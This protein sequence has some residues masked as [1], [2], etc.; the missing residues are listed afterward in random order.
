MVAEWVRSVFCVFDK[1]PLLSDVEYDYQIIYDPDDLDALFYAEPTASGW[2]A[3]K[4]EGSHR[5]QALYAAK[6]P[7]DIKSGDLPLT[8]GDINTTYGIILGNMY[9]LYYPFGK[10]FSFVNDVI[11]SSF[12]DQLSEVLTD[13]VDNIEDEL[14]D[15]IYVRE[16]LRYGEACGGLAGFDRIFASS[17]SAK[18]LT[19]DPEVL[20]LRDRLIAENKDQLHDR[21]VQAKIEEAVVAAD[22]KSFEN[23]PARDYLITSKSFNPTRKKQLIMIGGSSGFGNAGDSSFIASSLRDKWKIPDI[24]VHANEA[25]AGSFFRGKETQYGGYDVKISYRMAMNSRVTTEFC[26]TKRGK[27]ITLNESNSKQMIGLYA[28][29]P[30]GPQLIT[31]DNVGKLLNKTFMYYSP[32]Y[33]KVDGSSFCATCIGKTYSR[34]PSGLPSV[35]ANIGDV[36]MYDK[37][38]RMHGKAMITVVLHLYSISY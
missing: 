33:C 3:K 20:A 26:G 22:K 25:R 38:K 10:K 30:N 16:Y 21:T 13:D 14:P 7:C 1:R 32:Q 5:N 37:M 8:H 35:V 31:K 17:G 27:P 23:D 24:P 15:R 2:V 19:V 12:D 34:L 36:Y 4:I 29:T 18:A 28:V 11:P 9:L 6:E